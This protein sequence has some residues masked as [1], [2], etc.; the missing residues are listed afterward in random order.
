MKKAISLNRCGWIYQGYKT[1][2]FVTKKLY[3]DYHDF[4]WGIPQY[5][6]KRLLGR[7][8]MI[9]SQLSWQGM[10]RQR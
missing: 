10:M 3:Q 5:E 2:D 1:A 6:D 8:L 7:L 9:L 4:E